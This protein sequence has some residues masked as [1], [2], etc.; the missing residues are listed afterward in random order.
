MET[1]ISSTPAVEVSKSSGARLTFLDAI[2]GIAAL[3]VVIEHLFAQAVPGIMSRLSPYVDF[4]RIGVTAFFL[5]SGFVIPMSIERAANL[6]LFWIGRGFRLYPAYLFSLLALAML[7]MLLPTRLAESGALTAPLPQSVWHW[8]ANLSLF[9]MFLG[10]KDINPVSWTLGLEWI[11]YGGCA[12]LYWRGA[13]KKIELSTWVLVALMAIGGILL[14]FVI[15]K[16]VPGA[17]VVLLLVAQAG[18]ISNRLSSRELEKVRAYGYTALMGVTS[19]AIIFVNYSLFKK[20]ASET[21]LPFLSVLIS[22]ALGCGLFYGGKALFSESAPGVLLWLGRVSYSLYLT[23]AMWLMV[24]N[25]SSPWLTL[26]VQIAGALVT[27]S[28]VF[29]FIES[30]A[31]A[32][33]KALGKR[34]FPRKA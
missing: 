18:L 5:V 4:G 6:R 3:L 2:R 21:Q 13:L 27:A 24:P 17:F 33:G 15:H 1:S 34:L 20:G 7:G 30:P 14:P 25:L 16:R 31:I 12:F 8:V 29:Q 23:H 28:L 11:I 9:Q 22:S 26:A 19:A 32:Y 10:V